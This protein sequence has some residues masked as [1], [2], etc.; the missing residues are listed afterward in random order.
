LLSKHLEHWQ[1]AGSKKSAGPFSTRNGNRFV[2][3][4]HELCD[5][6]QKLLFS[7]GGGRVN[8]E[9]KF[10]YLGTWN[11]N[12]DVLENTFGVIHFHCGSN[13]NLSVGQSVDALKTVILNGL[14]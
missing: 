6:L 7:M 10:K 4:F 2:P 1:N 13:S 8:E 9:E 12:Q 14:V 5:L 3:L 11:L